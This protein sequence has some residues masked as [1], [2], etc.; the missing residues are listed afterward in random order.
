MVSRTMIQRWLRYPFAAGGPV[1][2]AQFSV[3]CLLG[4]GLLVAEVDA[5]ASVVIGMT[6][7]YV[8]GRLVDEA[9]RYYARRRGVDLS[10]NTNPFWF[11]AT[12]WVFAFAAFFIGGFLA[13]DVFGL[14]PGGMLVFAAPIWFGLELLVRVVVLSTGGTFDPRE[15]IGYRPEPTHAA[16]GA[17]D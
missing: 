7:I 5:L 8:L 13:H 4:V 3:W 1:S 9:K 14:G 15:A 2:A 11:R 10:A 16:D 12:T 17:V 6:S